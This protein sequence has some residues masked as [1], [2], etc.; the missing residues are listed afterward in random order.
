MTR[1]FRYGVA[2]V[3]PP[4]NATCLHLF[5]TPGVWEQGEASGCDTSCG[6]A[7]G[8]GTPGSVTCSETTG[9]KEGDKPDAKQCP[10][11]AACGAWG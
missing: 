5:P 4:S 1:G 9:C 10:A 2:F 7:E 8:S 3:L 11:T 6:V